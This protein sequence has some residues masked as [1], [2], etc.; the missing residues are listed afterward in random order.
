MNISLKMFHTRSKND[1]VINIHNNKRKMKCNNLITLHPKTFFDDT[2]I[3]YLTDCHCSFKNDG[4]TT[5]C[6]STDDYLSNFCYGCVKKKILKMSPRSKID[7]QIILSQFYEIDSIPSRRCPLKADDILQSEMLLFQKNDI[8][9]LDKEVM[10]EEHNIFSTPQSISNLKISS[11]ENNGLL[12]I[13][14]VKNKK[15]HASKKKKLASQQNQQFSSSSSSF[16]EAKKSESLVFSVSNITSIDDLFKPP[17]IEDAPD[18]EPIAVYATYE[19]DLNILR[20]HETIRSRY[21]YQLQQAPILRS[22]SLK[23]TEELKLIQNQMTVAEIMAEIRYQT[24]MLTVANF[25]ESLDGW[26]LYIEETKDLIVD[27]C[28]LQNFMK[29]STTNSE[30][31]GNQ[32]NSENAIIMIKPSLSISDMKKIIIQKYI[33]RAGKHIDI[34]AV[35]QPTTNSL[36]CSTCGLAISS[37]DGKYDNDQATKEKVSSS[38]FN[39]CQCNKDLASNAKLSMFRE[40]SRVDNTSRA[41][42][43]DLTTYIK[44]LDAFEGKQ[45]TTPSETLYCIL[46]EFFRRNSHL[47]GNLTCEEIKKMPCLANGKKEHTSIAILAESLRATFN[48]SYY[49]DI[50]LIGHRLWGWKLAD[51]TSNGLKELL[52]DDYKRTQKVYD[53]IKTRESS[54]NINIRVASHLRSRGF[55]C[56]LSDFKIVSGRESLLYHEE[57]LSQ[58]F[59]KCGLPYHSLIE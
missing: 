4:K 34:I 56:T 33:S 41:S 30:D 20:I 13:D 27:Y 57:C 25:S 50:D 55:P 6:C 19:D 1:Y 24:Q 46:R 9:L 51:L 2:E 5:Y 43:D 26:K 45:R 53:I 14:G 22:E 31:D 28:N 42:Y 17:S 3:F 36:Q 12:L 39:L 59:E 10:G 52:I 29:T 49:R 38:F 47:I 35:F 23:K 15:L 7:I 18:E 44:R 21:S 8:S 54:L 40:T 16:E 32:N 37:D 11:L 48:S 58:M